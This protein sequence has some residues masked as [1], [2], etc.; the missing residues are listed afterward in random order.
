M[1]RARLFDGVDD[2]GEPY[3]APGHPRLSEEERADVVRFLD[4]GTVIRR[5]SRLDVD[6]V[7]PA[8]GNVVPMTVCTDGTWLWNRGLRYYV[9][10]YGI[11]PEPEFLRHMAACEY[12][13]IPADEQ[14][15]QA[16]LAVLRGRR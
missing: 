12:V 14:A 15:R 10:R 7:E 11:A 16:A 2:A 9:E 3:F 4:S 6:R 5:V 13:A 1:K 8:R